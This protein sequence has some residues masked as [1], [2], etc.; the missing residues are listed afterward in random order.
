ML[1]E[2]IDALFRNQL[3]GHQSPP[4]DDL[5]A[6]LQAHAQP[7][8][9]AGATPAAPAAETNQLDELFRAR[10]SQHTISPPRELWE[11]LEDEHLRP[12]KRRAAAWWPMAMAAAVA[13]L[14]LVGGGLLWQGMPGL[15]SGTGSVARVNTSGTTPATSGRPAASAADAAVTTAEAPTNLAAAAENEKVEK[16]IAAQA[17]GADQLSS[18]APEGQGPATRHPATRFGQSARTAPASYATLAPGGARQSGP[19]AP[20][21]AATAHHLP[22]TG[23]QQVA[24]VPVEPAVAQV[25]PAPAPASAEVIEVEVRR[26]GSPAVAVAAAPA[27]DGDD[28]PEASRRLGRLFQR[29]TG[30]VRL[31]KDGLAAA[32]NLPDN[33][34]VQAR[35]GNHTLS[36]TIE[37]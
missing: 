14:L 16:N 5:W 12:R 13:L 28:A 35:L 18:S 19:T 7:A 9:E 21:H 25:T 15:R 6:R 23:V 34:T 4:S 2:D 24:P 31:A 29:A 1:P 32:Q 33:L 30:A 26:G 22:T 10:L 11:R 3:D 37:L 36:K 8:P 20:A 17:T 27:A